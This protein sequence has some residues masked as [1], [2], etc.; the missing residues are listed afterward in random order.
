M[1]RSYFEMFNGKDFDSQV[2]TIKSL[3]TEAGFSV[4]VIVRRGCTTEYYTKDG[5]TNVF[6]I[7]CNSAG[8]VLPIVMPMWFAEKFY[9]SD[10]VF[11]KTITISTHSW[12]DTCFTPVLNYKG[13]R[14]YKMHRA[15]MN[16]LGEDITGLEVDHITNHQGI[17]IREEL[18]TCTSSENHLNCFTRENVKGEFGYKAEHDFRDSFWIPV[19][20][21]VLGVISYD[22]MHELRSMMIMSKAA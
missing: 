21:Y 3:L 9:M 10:G 7:T 14:N 4:R 2:E 12:K 6:A 20:H 1:L 22:D 8:V 17:N 15:I 16:E 11:N 18:R 19:L 5:V 13:H